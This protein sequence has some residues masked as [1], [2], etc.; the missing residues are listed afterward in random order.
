MS[1]GSSKMDSNLTAMWVSFF[2]AAGIPSDVG[3]TYALTFTE[4]RIQSDMLLD[5][6]KEYLKDMGI[7]RMGD[8]IAILRH[9]KQVH[10]STARDRVLSTAASTASQK[11]PVAAITGR[12]TTSSPSSPASRMLEHYTRNSHIQETS[13]TSLTQKRKHID[14]GDSDIGMKKARL[15][16]FGAPSAPLSSLTEVTKQTVFARLGDNESAKPVPTNAAAKPI[17]SRLGAKPAEDK[18]MPIDKHALKY[19]GILKTSSLVKKVVTVTTS[20]NNI[21]KIAMNACTM[22]ADETPVSVKDKLNIPKT[23]SVKFSSHVQYKEIESSKAK[24]SPNVVPK[25]VQRNIS[26]VTTVFNK[27]ER[28]LSMPDG[29]NVK[30]RLGTKNINNLTVTKNVFNRLGV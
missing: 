19:E 24:N 14:V 11:V 12:S 27:P 8:V 9:A 10:E 30:N 28:R 20:K 26:K 3:A 18:A 7:V 29:A 21:R 4:N 5:L 15:I 22:R 25:I 13:P 6:N 17:Y 23:K 2:T 16:R 1:S